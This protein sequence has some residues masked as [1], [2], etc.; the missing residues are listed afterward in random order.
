MDGRQRIALEGVDRP[1]ATRGFANADAGLGTVTATRQHEY[2][3]RMTVTVRERDN[4]NVLVRANARIGEDTVTNPAT[5]SK[6]CS[7]SALVIQ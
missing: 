5:T 2:D 7:R 4:K 1:V 3:M 6:Q